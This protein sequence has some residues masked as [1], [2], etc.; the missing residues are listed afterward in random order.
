MHG[1]LVLLSK[2]WR[3][4]CCS[5]CAKADATSL[6]A[7]RWYA[8]WK[9][10]TTIGCVRVFTLTL[11]CVGDFCNRPHW[12]DKNRRQLVY[13]YTM[14]TV[15]HFKVIP[16]QERL[17]E[18]RT[19]AMWVDTKRRT[20][21]NR[22]IKGFLWHVYVLCML[23]GRMC[24]RLLRRGHMDFAAL[25]LMS[26]MQCREPVLWPWPCMA[27]RVMDM[28]FHT[29]HELFLC[30]RMSSLFVLVSLQRFSS[31]FVVVIVMNFIQFS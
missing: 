20:N 23:S 2:D 19:I 6:A 14:V 30:R 26:G 28:S 9:D 29:V 12:N 10:N 1:P 4:D 24:C 11:F 13:T 27:M 18:K 17:K 5:L 21:R 3:S 7:R 22:H 16:A 15:L 31:F 8:D 25:L